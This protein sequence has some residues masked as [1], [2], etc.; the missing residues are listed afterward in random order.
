[1]DDLQSAY[2]VLGVSS[3]DT[4]AEIKRVYRSLIKQYHPDLNPE[5]GEEGKKKVQELSIAYEKICKSHGGAESVEYSYYDP[6]KDILNKLNLK[7]ET[8]SKSAKSNTLDGSNISLDLE[9]NV[10]DIMVSASFQ[11]MVK[12]NCVCPKCHGEGKTLG[13]V[14]DRCKGTGYNLQEQLVSFRIP[15]GISPGK[16]FVV[17][18]KGHEGLR[19]GKNGDL[20]VKVILCPEEKDRVDGFNLKYSTFIN[21]YTAIVGGFNVLEIEGRNIEYY[22]PAGTNSGDVITIK[23]EGLLKA[24]KKHYGDLEIGI[25]VETPK[26]LTDEQLDL[27]ESFAE[28]MGYI[29]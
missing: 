28:S 7:D 17:K 12:R 27:L 8:K 18:G 9:V 1:M 13:I 15:R 11:E 22:V 4:L 6:V 29:K 5:K 19:G 10:K 24:D 23:G 16:Q 14:C 2:E 21:L 20:Y 3:S 25:T 26:G